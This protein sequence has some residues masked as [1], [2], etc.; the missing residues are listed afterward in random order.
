MNWTEQNWRIY[1]NG[2]LI[3]A[4][5]RTFGRLLVG[6]VNSNYPF[7]GLHC[8]GGNLPLYVSGQT[9]WRAVDNDEMKSKSN[10][11]IL[12]LQSS[13]NF[14]QISITLIMN[15]QLKYIFFIV[16]NKLVCIL[17]N[18]VFSTR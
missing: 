16:S 17:F 10:I 2:K 11:V 14:N 18:F 3:G 7:N 5:Q 8:C 6:L 9:R 12:L 1:Y 15:G 13:V 4:V